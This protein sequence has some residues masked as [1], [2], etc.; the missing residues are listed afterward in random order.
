MGKKDRIIICGESFKRGISH[1]KFD[2]LYMEISDMKELRKF[3]EFTHLESVSLNGTNITDIGLQYIAGCPTIE[4]IN[5]TFTEITDKGISYLTRLKALKFLRL[6]DTRISKKS[7]PYFNQ[8]TL[9]E[10]LQ[11]HETEI[12][13]CDLLELQIH[14]L[15]E[16][17]VD[18]DDDADFEALL[19]VSKR[20]SRCHIYVKS[21]GEFHQGIFIAN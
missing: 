11:V 1:F 4:N 12:S 9:L 19:E 17:S 3:K 20:S 2:T 10:S 13:G 5:L 18:C 7:I 6:K 14:N 15:T 16:I 8:M 21:K